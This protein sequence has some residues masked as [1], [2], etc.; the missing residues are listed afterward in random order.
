[1]THPDLDP[2]A[3]ER[4][5]TAC[6][7]KAWELYQKLTELMA[8]RNVTLATIG[9]PENE[10]RERKIERL[11]HY[12]DMVVAGQRRAATP[13]YGICPACGKPLPLLLL[14]ETPWQ[15]RHPGCE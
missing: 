6:G 2:A 3:R 7:K 14:Q 5:G 4:L 9:L 15:E 8:G 10:T 1:M 12:F 13:E 11:R